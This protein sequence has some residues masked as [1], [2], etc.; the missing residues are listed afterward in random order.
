MGKIRMDFQPIIL[1]LDWPLVMIKLPFGLS[2]QIYMNI[3][4]IPMVFLIMDTVAIP[5]LKHIERLELI[6]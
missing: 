2:R 1:V 6:L 5:D 3:I 4:Q